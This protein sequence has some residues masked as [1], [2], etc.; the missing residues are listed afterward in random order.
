MRPLFLLFTAFLALALPAMAKKPAPSPE[1]AT[2]KLPK[3]KR[4]VFLGDSITHSGQYIEYV[5][6]ILLAQT[7]KRYDILDL[8]LSSETVSGLSEP[9]HADGAFPRPVLRERIERV[10][11]KTKP[12]LVVAC[13]GMNDG[14]YYPYSDERFDK[15]A[16]GIER[17]RGAVERHDAHIIH[18]TPPVFDPLPIKEKVL[19]AGEKE[20]RK[21]FEGYNHVLDV[22]SEKL[23]YQA[24][25]FGWRVIDIHSP[26]K[27][28][29]EEGRKADPS[30][31]FAKD[32]VHPNAEG[33]W[34]M[35][36]QILH[37]W[38]V[39]HNFTLDDLTKPDGKLFALHK[40]EA[41]RLHVR[42]AAWLSACGHKRPGVKPGLP[43]E[44]AEQKGTELTGQIETE[45]ARLR[46][47]NLMHLPKDDAAS[48]L[49]TGELKHT[50]LP[51][52]KETDTEL[53]PAQ[54]DWHGFPEHH[55][56]VD[57]KDVTVVSPTQ[58]AEG[59]PW[60]WHGEFFGHKPD[61]DIA[62]LGKGF[63][64]VYVKIPD[65]LGS[66]SAVGHWNDVYNVLTKQCHFNKKPA[67][68]GLSRGGLYCYNW[69]IANPT[70]VSCIYGDAPVCDFKSWPGG[71]GKGKGDKHNWELVM[72]L[73]GF[74]DEAD[75]MAYKGNP[76]DNLDP[77]AKAHVPLLHVFGEADDVVPPDENTLLLA[78]RYRKLDGTIELIGKP[79]VGHHPHG[80]EDSTPIV[81]FILK[82]AG[83]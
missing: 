1:P 42:S 31:V 56:T 15:F 40:L 77:L 62:L 19:P 37:F 29:L 12:D 3:A 82:N 41:E 5:E 14:I 24:H 54:K 70:K 50:A 49:P 21:P 39:D 4:I 27:A 81:N 36:Q 65:M 52:K 2:N 57:E 76:V 28:A 44:E 23:L 80:L 66:P 32:G 26:L 10:L 61:P 11:S 25:H 20:Y 8:G 68:V 64:I 67:L 35:A 47:L 38:G 17:L 48:S 16:E 71:K 22:Y 59:K 74:K 45:I 79:G 30:F 13:Y 18:L 78:E 60:C 7:T 55:L 9:G 75:A 58:E 73:W 83:K 53:P 6:T 69:A 33:H 43:L 63:H 46:G 51:E 72:K 34:I